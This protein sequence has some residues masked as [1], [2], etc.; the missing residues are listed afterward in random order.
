MQTKVVTPAIR[1]VR[2]TRIVDTEEMTTE[3][4]AGC[5]SAAVPPGRGR[6]AWRAASVVS[7]TLLAACSSSTPRAPS[8]DGVR[9]SRD[10]A[11]EL[12]PELAARNAA[13]PAGPVTHMGRTVLP[14]CHRMSVGRVESRAPGLRGAETVRVA[15]E[16][17]LWGPPSEPDDPPLYVTAGEVGVL[18]ATGA[19]A[20]FLLRL[21][22]SGNF[23]AVE[24]APLDDAQGAARLDSFR[25]ILAI[26][27]MSDPAARRSALLVYL[28]ECLG[29]S[30][31][32][33]R[34]YAVR[35]YA[36]F[37]DAFP[38]ALRTPDGDA[39]A[40]VLPAL[41]DPDLKRLG[42]Y[43]LDRVKTGASAAKAPPRP[44]L[45]PAVPRA[46]LTAFE[47]KFRSKEPGERRAAVLDAVVRHGLAAEPLVERALTDPDPAVRE[48]AVT[49]AGETG[50]SGLAEKVW[51]TYPTET[52]PIARR[53]LV[54][55]AG[56]LRVA[57]A[58]PTLADIA[59]GGGTLW[60][61]ASFALGRIRDGAAL[62]RLAVIE[63]TASDPERAKLAKFL[64]SDDFVR[65]EKALGEP[66]TQD[67]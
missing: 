59:A 25:R 47:E 20:L 66:W 29:G 31:R 24:V 58:V 22:R 49:G 15:E 2:L 56:K 9:A 60:R 42:Q 52:H 67:L 40:A 41:R 43:A 37:A 10:V 62:E 5:A 26:E 30:D 28:R 4:A 61:E 46:D 16:E 44:K 45:R 3:S 57:A 13:D 63:R 50:M 19:R 54:T 38:G 34:D 33:A 64:R 32:W 6:F 27:G 39:L 23:E 21:L 1:D 53:S 7:L 8:A 11:A 12:N 51:A 17:T 65:Q 14:K 55:A 35:E 18:P 48:A 36:A